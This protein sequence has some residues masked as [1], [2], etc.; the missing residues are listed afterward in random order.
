VKLIGEGN[1]EWETMRY[2]V[3]FWINRALKKLI[4]Q[5]KVNGVVLE[6]DRALYFRS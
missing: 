4:P 2:A 1:W 6:G 5:K 3:R